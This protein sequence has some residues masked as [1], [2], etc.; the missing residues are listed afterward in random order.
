VLTRARPES[1]RALAASVALH[2]LLVAAL[3]RVLLLPL[4][5]SNFLHREHITSLPAERISFIALPTTAGPTI[6]GKSGGNDRPVTHKPKPPLVAPPATPSVL[7]PAPAAPAA[8][9]PADEPD[10]GTGPVVGVGGPAQGV[11]PEYHDPRVWVPPAPYVSAPKSLSESVDS[12]VTALVRAHN[13][14]F[15]MSGARRKPGDWTV[16]HN[17]KK[18]GIDPQYIRLGP[19][20]IP[21]AVLAALPLNIQANPILG[22]NERTLT[23]RH[24]EIVEQAQRTINEDEFRD[25]VRKLRQRKERERE[26]AKQQQGDG[27]KDQ[28]QEPPPATPDQP[29]VVQ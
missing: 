25:A 4:P 13:D 17:G 11:R 2:V 12:A 18:Y 5:F 22:A 26:E 3:V 23:A 20:S 1:R 19:I 24:D 9:V 7:P 29:P 14:T 10:A 27:H 28:H 15:A 16:E 8:P 6:P 21:T